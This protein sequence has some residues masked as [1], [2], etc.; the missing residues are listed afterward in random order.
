MSRLHASCFGLA[1]ILFVLSCADIGEAQL[2]RGR[3]ASAATVLTSNVQPGDFEGA[4][5]DS[6][7]QKLVPEDMVVQKFPIEDWVVQKSA[8]Q[9]VYAQPVSV[10]YIQHCPFRKYGCGAPVEAVLVVMNPCSGCAVN[11]PVCLPACCV[12]APAVAAR[13][14]LFGRQ[15]VVYD[16]SCGYSIRFVFDRYGGLTVHYYGT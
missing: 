16:W 8:V 4:V 1:T 13:P 7:V 3:R 15:I 14:G 11:V 9:V 6:V 5:Q 10:R 12:D 2:L